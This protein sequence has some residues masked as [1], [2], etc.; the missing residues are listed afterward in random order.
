MNVE[1]RSIEFIP[2]NERHGNVRNLFSIWFSANTNVMP[3]LNGCMGIVLGLNIFWTLIAMILGNLIGGLF[4]AFHSAQG[5]K[6]G[7][8]QMISSR[9]QFGVI[10]AAIPIIM[11]FVGCPLFG[12]AESLLVVDAIKSVVSV[13]E[14]IGLVIFGVSTI[15]ITFFGYDFIHKFSNVMTILSLI[16]FALTTVFALQLDLPA[17]AWSASQGFNL[18]AFLVVMG[19]GASWQIGYGPCVA[20]YSRYL[21]AHTS[22]A[23][24]FWYTYTGTVLS[25]IWMPLVGAIIA[26]GIPNAADHINTSIATLFGPFAPLAYISLILGI[27]I[28]NTVITYSGYMSLVTCFSYNK[29][30]ISKNS[31]FWIIT[32]I[33]ALGTIIAITTKDHF[34]DYFGDIM[35]FQMYYLIPWTSVNLIDFYFFRKGK[36]NIPEVYDVNGVYGKYNWST[37]AV[38]IVSFFIQIPFMSFSFYKGPMFT[39]LGG[40][41][42]TWIVGLAASGILYY[43]FMGSKVKNRLSKE[44]NVE[45]DEKRVAQ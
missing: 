34:N 29:Q 6:L 8:P 25:G 27:I 31:K 20:D 38:Y 18:G 5:P 17:G 43:F 14:V 2:H 21:P 9:V 32:F 36:Y 13:P 4:M 40:A 22:T 44:F 1:Q 35:V 24:T 41:D 30:H 7:I 19:L 42:I 39:A 23:S 11:V 28:M 33:V 26:A 45:N 10:G 16:T 3:L 37:M 12:A 15:F